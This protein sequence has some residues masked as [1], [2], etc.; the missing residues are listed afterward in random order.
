MNRKKH[1]RRLP[2]LLAVL[3]LLSALLLL[4]ASAQTA[5]NPAADVDRGTVQKDETVYATLRSD[6][7]FDALYVVNRF[8]VPQAG[9]YTD[10]GRYDEIVSLTDGTR[11][12]VDGDVIRWRFT[13]AHDSYA[14]QGK[15]SA[16]ALPFTFTLAYTLNGSAVTPEVV[17]GQAGAVDLTLTVRSQ[18][19]ADSWLRE[20]MTAQIQVPI[21][22][23]A[24]EIVAAEGASQVVTGRTATLGYMVLP[25]QSLTAHITLRSRGF[26]LDAVN[27]SLLQADT[28]AALSTDSMRDFTKLQ[29]GAGELLDGTKSLAGGLTDLTQG[30]GDLADGSATLA[31]GAEGLR[32]GTDT[33]IEGIAS[34][35][36]NLATLKSASAKVKAGLQQLQG[37]G[38][39]LAGGYK[40]LQQQIDASLP[41]AAELASLKQ[42][43]ALVDSPDQTQQT[44]GLLAASLVTQA[45]GLQTIVD[46]LATLNASLGDY[47]GGVSSLADDYAQLDGGIGQAADG[48]GDMAKGTQDL[49]SGGA[50]LAQGS[51]ELAQGLQQLQTETKTLPGDAK[52]L[53]DGQRQLKDGVDAAATALKALAGGD[54]EAGAPVSFA[55]PGRITPAS[56]Q[57][58][59]RTQ[60]ITLPKAVV[61]P[62]PEETLSFWQRFLRLFGF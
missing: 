6:G 38:K 29:D 51:K 24:N 41:S 37:G 20:H 60:A 18:S 35:A 9:I 54:E 49:Q 16:G 21:D 59:L 52:Q 43:A 31:Q 62:Q 61:A 45:D 44:I 13:Q 34:F 7:T 27:I 10:Y 48:A 57:F 50:A 39:E 55:A 2:A 47:T 26:A 11:P 22:L 17:A 46:T 30:I 25:G 33:L 40:Q 56:I 19:T 23:S 53:A 4:P 58:V 5:D 3:G 28:S 14:Y 1:I 32:T 36:E 15:L 42:M 8:A 12:Q